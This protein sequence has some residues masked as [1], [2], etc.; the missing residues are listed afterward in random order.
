M[1]NWTNREIPGHFASHKCW[2]WD[3][4]FA[5]RIKLKLAARRDPYWATWR[6]ILVR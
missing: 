2:N 4:S 6:A 3:V 5:G 1:A